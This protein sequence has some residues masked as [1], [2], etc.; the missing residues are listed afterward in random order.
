MKKINKSLPSTLELKAV[1][2]GEIIPIKEVA[3]SIF[4]EKMIGDGYGLLPSVCSVNYMPA[5]CWND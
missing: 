1:M 5:S 2:D 3:D 4:S